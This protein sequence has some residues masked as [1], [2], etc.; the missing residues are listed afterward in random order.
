MTF[1]DM[2]QINKQLFIFI[3]SLLS[4]YYAQATHIIGGEINYKCLGNNKYQIALTVYRD[5]FYGVP[6]FDPRASIGVF[7]ND[8]KLLDSL[9]IKFLKDDTLKVILTDT[10]LVVP[11]DV[12]VHTT[13]YLDTIELMP[14]PGGYI[15]SYQRCCR[16]QTILNIVKPLDTGATFLVAISE[17]AI[18]LC[19]SNARFNTWPPI[20][21]CVNEQLKFD[22]SATDI[23]GDSIYYKL[24]TP[25]N[26][27]S[28]AAPAPQPPNPPPYIN[29]IWKAPFDLNNVLG[30][31]PLKIDPKTGLMTAK[32]NLIGQFVAG[33]CIDEF[34][35]GKLISTTRRDFQY[36]VGACTNPVASFFAPKI[37]CNDLDVK[38]ENKS[39]TA[40]KFEWDFG[41]STSTTDI[42]KLENPSYTYPDYGTYKIRMIAQPNTACADTSFH[43]LTLKQSTLKT[44]FTYKSEGCKDSILLKLTNTSKDVAGT[45]LSYKW[46]LNPQIGTEKYTS[47]AKD[48]S[49]YITKS[50]KWVVTLEATA[51]NGCPIQKAQI[52]DLSFID[53]T[54]QLQY[55]GC[56][57]DTITLNPN[58]NKT[59][60]YEWT[61][62]NLFK[63][64]KAISPKMVVDKVATIMVI[65]K[66]IG[67]NCALNK[68]LTIT[69]K[70]DL[71]FYKVTAKP[72]TI[73]L[74]KTSQLEATQDKKT[75]YTW[76]PAA[77]LSKSNIY[78]P[79]AKP[80]ET[81]TYN[82]KFQQTGFCTT[83]ER[84]TVVVIKP[85]CDEPFVYIPN[86]FSPNYDDVNDE[87]YV[88]GTN[89]DNMVL[90]I[91]NRW[92]ERVFFTEN[93]AIP[94]DGTYSG[95]E[96]PPDVYGFYLQVTCK[97]GE[98]YFKKGNITLL[99]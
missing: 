18:K 96:L 55:T 20:F 34:R 13:T 28:P 10:C 39:L 71:A 21:I 5:C 73:Y 61:P 82:V 3:I 8:G 62:S 46:F 74:G 24:C 60:E 54:F 68:T 67:E 85:T 35:K 93:Q 88:R 26:G 6:P 80:T 81:T 37:Q 89:I 83:T 38:F 65:A 94:W 22:Q 77:T 31:E 9:E 44:D 95:A 63:D 17:D 30:G 7:S 40:N 99:R 43:I 14:R 84:V 48:T 97:D 2:K 75:T 58:G 19:N 1:S 47:K 49:F 4:M 64:N 27:A 91:Y 87:L 23:D 69:P 53:S 72:D 51:I 36:N 50:G 66:K 92:G 15:L 98:K 11:K 33:V 29:V 12:C 78:N 41:D 86:A 42:S 76:L 45:P 90:A 79:V 70:A 52:I 25:F 57:G 32:P 56:K 59:F 16:N